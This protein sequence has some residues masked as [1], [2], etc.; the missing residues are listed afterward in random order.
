MLTAVANNRA[1]VGADASSR[2]LL[3]HYKKRHCNDKA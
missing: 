1:E 3:T 2:A